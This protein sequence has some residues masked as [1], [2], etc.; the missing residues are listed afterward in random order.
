[1]VNRTPNALLDNDY[2]SDLNSEQKSLW[3]LIPNSKDI[4]P[5]H[6]M[7]NPSGNHTKGYDMKKIRFNKNN[8]EA[9][10]MSL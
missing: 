6:K 4:I 9:N 8:I 5:F 7:L 2:G 3:K 10:I 1:M